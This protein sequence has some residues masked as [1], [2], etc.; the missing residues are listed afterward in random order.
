MAI[1]ESGAVWGDVYAALEGKGL[2][3]VG[4]GCAGVGVAGLAT[5][6]GIAFTSRRA[7]LA[8][9]NVLEYTAVLPNGT[10]ARARWRD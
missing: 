2:T 6:G 5:A 10:M 1:V 9:D 3:A 8:S 7:G 4:G